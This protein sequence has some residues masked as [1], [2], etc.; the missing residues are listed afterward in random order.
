M[1]NKLISSRWAVLKAFAGSLALL[2]IVAFILPQFA[3]AALPA[4]TQITNSAQ[5]SY[6]DGTAVQ[7]AT[8]SVTV[9]VALI[10]S[11][12]VIVAGG[13]QT[14]QYTGVDTQLTNTFD[15]TAT[16]NGPDQYSLT[17][18]IV[19]TPTNTT[20]A[21]VSL[22]SPSSPAWIG[23]TITLAGSTDTVLNVPSDGTAD[24]VV[25]YIAVGD[26][27]VVSGEV[28]TVTAVSDPGGSGTA[29]ITL[30]AALSSAPAAGVLV[31][32]RITVSVLVES[33]T[34][35]ASGTSIVVV[36]NLTAT[37]VTDTDETT[38]S[39]NVT[40]TYTSGLA[41]FT[42]YV[43][44]VTNAVAGSDSI[45]YQGQTY[46]RSG[47]T[48]LTAEVLE[49]LI[50]VTNSGSGSISSCVVT[51]SLPVVYADF[52]TTPYSGSTAV[53]Y[54]NESG[55]ASYLTAAADADAATWASPSLTVYVGTGATSSA[56][57]TIA[58]SALVHVLYQMTVK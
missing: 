2:A 5:L 43:R 51:D 53:T 4:N 8:S 3:H 22:T 46:Y 19:G 26:T 12:P 28:R 25:N 54:Y 13:N 9:T 16:S 38:T 48:A 21:D 1:K 45:S 36:K 15:V 27:V 37:S 20:G 23:A 17:P 57:G 55:T 56:G 39:G 47:V 33:G 52:N 30:N 6:N 50:V 34:I 40:D 11:A 14:T 35:T 49:Y 32:E 31:A 42:K 41:T 24:A 7:T 29:T 44:N 58:A 18:A 10:P